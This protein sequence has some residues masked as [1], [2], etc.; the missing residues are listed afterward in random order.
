M[1]V[2]AP[3]SGET[4]LMNSEFRIQSDAE[5]RIWPV[6]RGSSTHYEQR[7][8][9]AHLNYI[10]ASYVADGLNYNFTAE[11]GTSFVAQ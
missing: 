7:T 2:P 9:R 5:T 10:T 3:L 6:L 8:R 11:H 1:R 4:L